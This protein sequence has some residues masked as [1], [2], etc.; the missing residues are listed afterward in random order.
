MCCSLYTV[1][2][3]PLKKKITKLPPIVLQR[4][5]KLR[6][7]GC[8]LIG[9]F[10]MCSFDVLLLVRRWMDSTYKGK[11]FLP[12]P[13][14]STSVRRFNCISTHIAHLFIDFVVHLILI[15]ATLIQLGPFS[16]DVLVD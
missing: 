1:G 15:A 9:L 12:V 4:Q 6:I 11:T 13:D 10:S 2:G 16:N 7:G 5:R 8:F 14:K 3:R